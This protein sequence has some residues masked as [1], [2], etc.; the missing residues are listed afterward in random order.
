MATLSVRVLGELTVDGIDLSQLDRKARTLLQLLALARGRPVPG[1]TLADALWGDR[2]PARPSDQLAVLASR[3]RRVLGRDR[4]EHADSGYRLHADRLDLVELEAVA[5]EAERR[6]AAGEVGGAVAA[7]RIALALVRGPVPEVPAESTWATAER[8]GAERLVV[9]ARRV[10]ATALLTAGQWQDA[11]EI[12]SADAAADPYDEHAVRMV[13]R[14]HVAAGRPAVALATYASLREVLAEELGSDPAPDTQA[15]HTAI[16]RGELPPVAAAALAPSLVGRTSQAAHLDALAQRVAADSTPRAALVSGEAGI[17][18]TTLL[19]AWAAGRRALGDRVLVGTCGAL[20]RS[21]PLDVVLSTI[22]DHLRGRPEADAVLGEERSLLAPLLGLTGGD[23]PQLRATDPSLGPSLLYAAVA[24]VLARIGAGDR[25]VLVVDDAHLAGQPLADWLAF[26]LRRRLPLLVVLGAR[27]YEGPSMPVTDEVAIGPLDLAQ[28]AEVVGAERAEDLFR[29]SGGHPL[30]LAELAAAPGG[31]L[32]PS[33]VA[34]ITARCDQLGPA[35]ELVRTAAVLGGVLDVE[36]LAEVLAR[37]ALDVLADVEHAVRAGL[38]VEDAG[39]HRF[40]HELVREALVSGTQPGRATL[41]HGAAGRALAQRPDADPVVVADHAR[42]GGDPV[43]AAGALRSAAARAAE[44]FDHA[45][46]EELLDQS[47]S[48]HADDRTRV[49]RARVRIRR[50]RYA[51]AETDALA[52]SAAGAERWETAAWAA[53]FDRRFDDALRYAEDG[54]L[55]ADPDDPTRVRCLVA[56]GRI[57]HARGD[58]TAAATRIEEALAAL[59]GQDRVAAAAWLGV[60]NAHRGDVDEA[61]RLLRP[62]TLPGLGV[63]HTSVTLHAHLFTGHALA[64]AGRAAEALT[65]F[66]RYT[67]E[68]ERRDVPRFAG[69]GLNFG[70]WVLRNVGATAAGRDAHVEAAEMSGDAIPELRV[71]AC[72]D[73]ADAHL[74]DGEPEAAAALLDSIRPLIAGD[75]VFGWRL[76]MKLQLLDARVRLDVG[77]PGGAARIAEDLAAAARLAGV[78]RYESCAGL[79][80]LWSAAASGKRTD[81]DDAWRA[82][83]AV[84][85]AV[86]VEAWWWAGATGAALGLDRCLARAEEL[87]DGL[88]R[89]SGPHADS[90]H[91]EAGRRL[92]R[93]RSGVSAR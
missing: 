22:G 28:V 25:V 43:L 91:H 6:E 30:F 59:R 77:D 53:Y 29:R 56:S 26:V 24:N 52:A 68:V 17:G 83:A 3:L 13:M 76:R 33:L 90:L 63:D 86:G 50:R 18:K 88:A 93:W 40:R 73:L 14:A 7:A 10:A 2:P 84:E 19:T 39:R 62:A 57:L 11:L 69:R 89:R 51:D 92:D 79:V 27:P 60:I 72:E 1:A 41:L 36:L 54:A 48:L 44:R 81:P 47:L 46:A 71:A 80:G 75:L 70:G 35:G 67:D 58:L 45:T 4:V 5:A 8:A 34:A 65:C 16:L 85:Q 31:E 32:P 64:V 21:T 37:R 87:A 42:R 82:L 66:E 49:A 38:L 23:A 9:R 12:S 78:R 74:R 55:A 15:L 61:L 20:D